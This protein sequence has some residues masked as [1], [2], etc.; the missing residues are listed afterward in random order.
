M[1]RR[2]D[3]SAARRR[4]LVT[5]YGKGASIRGLAAEAGLSYGAVRNILVLA[6]VALRPPGGPRRKATP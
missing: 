4:K 1:M 6:G 2:V 5:Q 3:V